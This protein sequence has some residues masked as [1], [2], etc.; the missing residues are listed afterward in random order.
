MAESAGADLFLQV[1]KYIDEKPEVEVSELLGRWA[2]T[3]EHGVLLGLL[4]RPVTLPDAGL[5]AELTDGVAR[6]LASWRRA[7]RH[8]VLAEVRQE[9][10]REKFAEYWALKRG[11]AEGEQG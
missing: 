4:Q 8:Q 2:G 6:L 7:D 11:L 9:P 3:P 1:V 5:Q 10:S